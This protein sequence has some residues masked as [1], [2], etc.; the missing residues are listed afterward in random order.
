V[1]KAS[2]QGTRKICLPN[3]EGKIPREKNNNQKSRAHN[4]DDNSIKTQKK[5][6]SRTGSA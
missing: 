4:D 3:E 6:A 1:K 5:T 2:R